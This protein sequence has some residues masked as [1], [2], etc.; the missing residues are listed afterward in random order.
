MAPVSV[1]ESEEEGIHEYNNFSNFFNALLLMMRV[2]TGENWQDVMI[3]CLNGAPCD[4][5]TGIISSEDKTCGNDFSYI[6]FPSFY[7][8]STIMVCVCVC[9]CVCACVCA[10]ARARM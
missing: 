10:C 3:S 5:T 8:I 9:T 4:N 7:F 6:F 1:D 2:I